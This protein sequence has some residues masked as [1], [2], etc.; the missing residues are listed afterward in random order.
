MALGSRS[1]VPRRGFVQDRLSR[2]GSS[3]GMTDVVGANLASENGVCLHLGC[4][5]ETGLEIG[6]LAVL[7]GG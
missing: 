7:S 2:E 6:G 5:R 4:R 1:G 3:K